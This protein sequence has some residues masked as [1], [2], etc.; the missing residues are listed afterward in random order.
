MGDLLVPVGR[1]DGE[2]HEDGGH[3]GADGGLGE[4]YVDGIEHDPERSHD[5]AVDAEH[6]RRRQQVAQRDDDERRGDQ[7]EQEQN[8][9]VDI[10]GAGSLGFRVHGRIPSSSAAMGER[11]RCGRRG[12]Q[13]E[14]ENQHQ[15]ERGQREPG[16][17]HEAQQDEARAGRVADARRMEPRED[18]RHADQPKAADHDEEGA[19]ADADPAQDVED[20]GAPS[21][22][23][24]RLRLM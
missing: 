22:S 5:E 23:R 12:E 13:E 18:V 20:H 19:E 16:L 2:Q 17:Q 24:D 10:Y 11:V 8:I 15:L 14:H 6:E 3:A 7:Q 21:A 1:G 4:G 9:D